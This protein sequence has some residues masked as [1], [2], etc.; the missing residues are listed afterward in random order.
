MLALSALRSKK[1]A[2]QNLKQ[3]S[4]TLLQLDEIYAKIEQAVDQVD[5]VNVMQDSTT[6][7]RTLHAQIGGVEKVDD[8]VEELRREMANVEEV[9]NV[10]SEPV[11]AIDEGELDDELEEME[12]AEREEDEKE[13]EATK[14]RLAELEQLGKEAPEKRAESD[15]ER[16]LEDR[17]SNMSIEENPEKA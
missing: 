6:A 3:R 12:N 5:I 10:I 11:H 14:T 13:A 1:L 7:L 15:L 16:E 4:D 9:N 2:E 17:L 8:V